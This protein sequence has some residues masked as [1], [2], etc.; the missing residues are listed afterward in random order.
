MFRKVIPFFLTSILLLG[1]IY[2][3]NFEFITH[4]L[5]DGDYC[6]GL[7][8]TDAAGCSAEVCLTGRSAYVS[9]NPCTGVTEVVSNQ[10]LSG[11]DGPGCDT[12]YV[13]VNFEGCPRI[14]FAGNDVWLGCT[15]NDGYNDGSFCSDTVEGADC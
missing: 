6:C 2:A 5:S 1:K 13:E 15:A 12:A 9:S 10:T 8:V 3:F 11:K 4:N 7:K 14:N